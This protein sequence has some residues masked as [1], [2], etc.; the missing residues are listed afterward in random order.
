MRCLYIQRHA[1]HVRHATP[2][3]L[4]RVEVLLV[5]LRKLPQLRERKRGYFSRGSR[6]FLHFHEDAGNLYVDVRL[7]SAF[8]RVR[9]TSANEQADLLSRVRKALQS[10]TSSD[11]HRSVDPLLHGLARHRPRGVD[12][13]GNVSDASGAQRRPGLCPIASDERG[14]PDFNLSFFTGEELVKK[15]FRVI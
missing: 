9:V 5:E 4:D 6:A 14:C 3:D 1:R 15:R 13:T 7:D 11:T 2:E 12:S 10:T 8:Q